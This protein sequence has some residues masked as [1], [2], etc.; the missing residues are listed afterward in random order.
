MDELLEVDAAE[1]VEA[2]AAQD[3]FFATLGDRL[4]KEMRDEQ[5]RL[6]Q[7]VD[8][9]ITPPDLRARAGTET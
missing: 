3:E 8:K 5:Q 9:L 1:W 6:A 7:S 2:L 4:P